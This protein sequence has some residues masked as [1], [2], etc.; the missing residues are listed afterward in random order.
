[1]T[2]PRMTPEQA[3]AAL[4]TMTSEDFPTVP[5]A[6]VYDED[7][8]QITEAGIERLIEAAH[9]ITG[10]PSL[11]APGEHSPALNL[12]IPVGTKRRLEQVARQRGVRQST[13]VREALD[14]YLMA[15]AA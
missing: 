8:H 7:G 11:T 2:K 1:M 14:E 10:R 3:S 5:L 15:A 12:R 6:D 9:K 13:I 4:A